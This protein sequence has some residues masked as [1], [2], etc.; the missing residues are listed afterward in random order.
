M[1]SVPRSIV[2]SK[3]LHTLLILPVIEVNQLRESVLFNGTVHANESPVPLP[4]VNGSTLDVEASFACHLGAQQ[5]CSA[6][7]QL[8]VSDDALDFI[9]VEFNG[10]I[11]SVD[12]PLVVNVTRPSSSGTLDASPTFLIPMAKDEA[13][14]GTFTMRVLVDNPVIEVYGMEGRAIGTYMHL[15]KDPSSGGVRVLSLSGNAVQTDLKVYSMGSAY[16]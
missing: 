7:L 6:A 9:Q 1:Q 13:F 16:A 12:E 5:R 4:G 14:N 2:Y 10:V 15:P 3:S 11:G 8:R